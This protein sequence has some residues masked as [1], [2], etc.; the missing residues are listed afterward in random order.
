M[1][2][3]CDPAMASSIYGSDVYDEYH[4]LASPPEPVFCFGANGVSYDFW[5]SDSLTSSR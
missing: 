1:H 3:R 4:A 5:Q 2:Y